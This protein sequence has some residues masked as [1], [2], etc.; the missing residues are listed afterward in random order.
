MW[1]GCVWRRA[2]DWK[3]ETELGAKK[4]PKTIP[5]G[6]KIQLQEVQVVSNMESGGALEAELQRRGFCK[7][8]GRFEVVLDSS[9]RRLGRVLGAF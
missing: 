2:S 8:R 4:R 6:S 7:P 5:Q 9:W 1:C 3:R